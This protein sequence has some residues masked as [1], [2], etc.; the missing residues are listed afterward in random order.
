M[1]SADGIDAR[2]ER[3][4][5]FHDERY[6]D[7]TRHAQ[8]KYYAAIKDGARLFDERVR[9]LAAGADVLE[10]GC[11]N[12]SQVCELAREA[13]SVSGVDISDVAVADA[14]TRA[15]AAGVSNAAFE[16]MNAEALTFADGSFDLVFGRGIIHH[17]EL[18]RCFEAVARVLRPRGAALF[19]EPLG[20]NV[21]FNL[22]RAMTPSV[23]TV[24]EHP[25][26]E[27]DF[28][29]ARR[30]FGRVSVRCFGLSSLLTVPFRDTPVGD[31]LLRATALVDRMLFCAPKLKWQ[32]WYCLAEL[33]EPAR[34]D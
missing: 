18:G 14:R 32:A 12:A 25:L 15:K 17:L 20:G 27:R 1:D 33:R 16:T 19:W 13:S 3:E 5:Q 4:R 23:R 30:H 26:R 7:E 8:G 24:D 10:L 29:L 11:G 28:I 31:G 9:E 2:I 22:Y 34:G 21:L 6:G